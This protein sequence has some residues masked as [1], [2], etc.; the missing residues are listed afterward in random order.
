MTDQLVIKRHR[1]RPEERP[2]EILDAALILFAEQGFAGT[3]MEDVAARAGLSKGAL[4][5]YFPDKVSLL[6]AIISHTA[7][8]TVSTAMA[9]V[10]AHRGPIAPL[11]ALILKLIAERLETTNLASVIKL[12]FSE[13]RAHPELGKAYLDTVINKAFPVVEGLISQGIASGEFRAV[14]PTMM[15]R[16]FIAPML[17]AAIWKSVIQPVGAPGFSIA[18]LATHHA[19]IILRALRP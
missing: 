19:D 6:T 10:S 9:M 15:V 4:Y 1:R 3:R 2:G 13:S 17:L 18:D 5:L 16:S 8:G 11:L 14:D 12:V 7:G